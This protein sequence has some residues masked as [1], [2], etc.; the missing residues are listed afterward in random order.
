[1]DIAEIVS[2]ID[3]VYDNPYPKNL[4]K[5]DNPEKIEMTRGKL[6]ELLHKAVENTKKDIIN[7]IEQEEG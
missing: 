3:D 5:W 2:L 1:M 7:I 6:N 4:F